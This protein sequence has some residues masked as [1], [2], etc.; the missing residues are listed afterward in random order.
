MSDL[1]SELEVVLPVSF[2]ER[3]NNAY[4]NSLVVIDADGGN[5]GL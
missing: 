5:R 1:A 2:F 3:A 4:Y